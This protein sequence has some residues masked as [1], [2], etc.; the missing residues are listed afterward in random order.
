MCRLLRG[1]RQTTVEHFRLTCYFFAASR[2]ISMQL[3]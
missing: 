3:I 2:A 1:H